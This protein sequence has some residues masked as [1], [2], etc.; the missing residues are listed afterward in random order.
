MTV[1]N[2]RSNYQAGEGRPLD[3]SGRQSR[4]GSILTGYIGTSGAKLAVLTQVP[5]K[6]RAMRISSALVWFR[7]WP[8]F[9]NVPTVT[10]LPSPLWP[11]PLGSAGL[12]TGM[13]ANTGIRRVSVTSSG[14]WNE[15]S[16]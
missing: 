6:I 9:G 2:W 15:E 3:C 5:L 10:T 13:D 8:F 11:F 12:D 16:R 4:C 7:Q 14:V 1:L